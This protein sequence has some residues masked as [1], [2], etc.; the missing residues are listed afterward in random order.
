MNTSPHLI[1]GRSH[2][3]PL[4]ERGVEQ[5]RLLGKYFLMHNILPNRLFT[6]PAVRAVQTAQYTSKALGIE[7]DIHPSDELQEMSQGNFVGRIRTEI[8]T[9]ELENEILRLGKDFKLP[10]G[11]S[12]N[13]VGDRMFGWVESSIPII[14]KDEVDRTF[15]FSHGVAISS[16]ISRLHNWSQRETF[17]S[18]KKNKNTAFTILTTRHGRWQ[19]DE[20]ASIP[21]LKDI[22]D[23]R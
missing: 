1:G 19:M 18:V 13:E 17:E 10:G 9:D 6:S 15:V 4:T 22:Y 23:Y 5:A 20:F 21:H 7:M 11:E 2:E 14:T 16:L 12:M 8:Y 3:T